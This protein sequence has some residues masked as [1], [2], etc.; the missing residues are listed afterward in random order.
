LHHPAALNG[1][2]DVDSS[3]RLAPGEVL[4]L[5]LEDVVSCG[6]ADIDAAAADLRGGF[7]LF[8]AGKIRNP[9]KCVLHRHEAT[10]DD[11]LVNAMG[12]YVDGRDLFGVKV[13]GSMPSNVAQGLPRGTGLILLCHPETKMVM[14]ILDAQAISATRTGAV[15]LLAAECLLPDGI[16]RIGLVGAGVNMRAPTGFDASASS[17][18]GST[19]GRSS[20][21][22]RVRAR[23]P[24]SW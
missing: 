6:G 12:A 23:C 10:E 21:R 5:S 18:R 9:A 24:M 8:A 11:G 13:I 17:G 3:H 4:F 14:A 15:T 19:C 20:S 22:S 16:R 1:G 2:F 7:S